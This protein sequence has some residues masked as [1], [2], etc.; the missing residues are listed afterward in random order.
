MIMM[1]NVVFGELGH[2]FGLRTNKFIMPMACMTL[3]C[4]LSVLFKTEVLAK[5]II[6]R[7]VRWG[8]SLIGVFNF[9]E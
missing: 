8:T 4:T 1:C 7:F 2:A 5:D 3:M 6:P 9:G